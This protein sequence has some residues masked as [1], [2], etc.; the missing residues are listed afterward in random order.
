[1][2]GI[3]HVVACF[4]S[5]AVAGV[6]NSLYDVPPFEADAVCH[7]WLSLGVRCSEESHNFRR[8]LVEG[9]LSKLSALAN[10]FLSAAKYTDRASYVIA[11]LITDPNSDIIVDV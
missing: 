5:H 9:S 6:C 7:C 3:A 10:I 2:Q 4:A 1:M 11:S 8:G